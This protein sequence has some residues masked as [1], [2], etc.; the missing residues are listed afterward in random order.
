MASDGM[1]EKFSLEGEEMERRL[2][3]MPL[4]RG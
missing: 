4:E 3:W 2:A 1:T